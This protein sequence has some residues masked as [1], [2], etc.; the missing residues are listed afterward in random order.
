MT[1]Y[2]TFITTDRDHAFHGND[3]PLIKAK[4]K[5]G[6]LMQLIKKEEVEIAKLLSHAGL[7]NTELCLW[8]YNTDKIEIDVNYKKGIVSY[9]T[10]K[11]GEEG[12]RKGKISF[13][14]LYDAIEEGNDDNCIEYT[15]IGL[16][17]I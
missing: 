7:L 13:K 10:S 11:T 9:D 15:I 8:D 16:Y 4:D 1:H 6:A 5:A 14:D 17:K 2:Y 12:G 3:G